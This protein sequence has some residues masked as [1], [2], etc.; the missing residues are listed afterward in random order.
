MHVAVQ[1]VTYWCL[2]FLSLGAALL[3]LNIYFSIIGNDLELRSLGAEAVV[4]GI[5]SLIE[6]VSA[7]LVVTFVPGA[8]RAL[9]IP[10]LI[11]ALI[12]KIAHFEDWDRFDIF[13]LFVFQIVLGAFG[14]ALFFG[15]FETAIIILVCFGAILAVV[16]AFARDLGG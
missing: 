16:A 11:V 5:A 4:A 7:W 12:Y 6:A 2:A 10:A 9:I 1:L 3:L 13:M 14:V 15:H 8:G